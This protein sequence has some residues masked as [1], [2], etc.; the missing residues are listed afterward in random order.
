VTVKRPRYSRPKPTIV[1]IVD[2]AE[3]KVLGRVV[4][5]TFIPAGHEGCPT[6]PL[7][8]ENPRC[9]SP[10]PPDNRPKAPWWWR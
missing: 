4:D 1:T 10:W 2:M 5:G 3:A 6:N 7:E 9:W 8:C